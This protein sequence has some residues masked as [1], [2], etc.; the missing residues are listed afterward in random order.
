MPKILNTTLNTKA[1]KRLS[2]YQKKILE[3]LQS[4]NE[5]QTKVVEVF[6]ELNFESIRIFC[7]YK[8]SYAKGVWDDFDP[9]LVFVFLFVFIA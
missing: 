6:S 2:V 3:Y 5:Y 9:K 8:L 7:Q 1:Q 4:S